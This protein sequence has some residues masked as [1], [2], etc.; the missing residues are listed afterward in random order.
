MFSCAGAGRVCGSHDF[1]RAGERRGVLFCDELFCE[2]MLW[3]H[4]A[5]GGRAVLGKL[6]LFLRLRGRAAR[7]TG[8]GRGPGCVPPEP[9]GVGRG[10]RRRGRGDGAGAKKPR[11]S[12]QTRF[13]LVT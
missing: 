10:E 8:R 6:T 11:R 9:N 3:A 7:A 1:V 4:S 13:Y 12:K 5:A 2:K